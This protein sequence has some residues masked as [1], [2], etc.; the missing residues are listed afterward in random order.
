MWDVS[1]PENQQ[2]TCDVYFG[3]QSAPPLTASGVT[4]RSYSPPSLALATTYYWRVRARDVLG[5]ETWGPL[6]TF[7]TRSNAPPNAPLAAAPLNGA[8]NQ[9]PNAALAWISLD[10]DGTALTHDVYFGME[11]DPPLVAS[12]IA[13]RGYVPGLLA[14]TTTYRWRIVVRDPLGAETSGPVWS[15]TTRANLAPI[16]PFNPVPANGLSSGLAPTLSWQTYDADLQPITNS[17][18]FGTT[19]PPPL[20]ESLLTVQSFDPGPLDA[21]TQYYWRVVTTDGLLSSASP[22]WT[23]TAVV[24]GDVVPDGQVTVADASCAL[25]LYLQDQACGGVGSSFAADVNCSGSVTPADARCIHRKVAD[26]SCTFCQDGTASESAVVHAPLITLTHTSTREDTLVARLAVS[27]IA[28]FASLGFSV[29]TSP[30]VRLVDARRRGATNSFTALDLHETSPG[31]AR[32]GGYSLSETQLVTT[33][34]F[35]ELRFDISHGLEGT[36]RL[37]AFVD[38]L[39][40]GSRYTYALGDVVSASPTSTG[41]ALHQNHPNPFN[42]QTTITY[43]LPSTSERVHVRLWII[44]IS[45]RVVKTLVDE[46]QSGGSYRVDWQGKDDRGESVSS[47]VYF[48][49]LDAGGERRT[50]KLVLLK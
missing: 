20:V 47:G 33:T 32:V 25:R 50:R 5:A 15:F 39:F 46:D 21:A 40:H 41:L 24:Y 49:A 34:E 4:N 42:P 19:L 17:V 28:S 29:A 48:F 26:G 30:K 16:V 8:V 3:T 9:P 12:N 10:P 22:I 45:G 36:L 37:E 1:D 13:T 23:F 11:A 31:A 43:D 44:D 2:I 35:I 27:P 18:Y 6:W 38:D 14:F 7:T